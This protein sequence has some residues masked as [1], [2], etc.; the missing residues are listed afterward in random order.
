VPPTRGAHP[1]RRRRRARLDRLK[2]RVDAVAF[3]LVVA[4]ASAVIF[5]VNRV[6]PLDPRPIAAAISHPASLAEWGDCA[7]VKA[8]CTAHETPFVAVGVGA[9][10][11]EVRFIC[12]TASGRQFVGGMCTT[13]GEDGC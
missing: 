9:N 3:V 8:A 13:V 6:P 11:C 5:Y 4:A 10:K 12:S 7:I 1:R 2:A